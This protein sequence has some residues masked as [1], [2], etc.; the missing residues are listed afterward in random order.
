M[1]QQ[2]YLFL[3]ILGILGTTG[4][5]RHQTV[6]WAFLVTPVRER[7]LAA[8]AL[9]YGLVGL[10]VALAAA[11]ATCVTA[12]VV[13]AAQGRQVF[14]PEVLPIL[15]GSVV[16]SALYTILGLGIGA[17]VRNQIAAVSVALGWFYY[18]EFLLV[19]FLPAIG[20]WA[21][22]GAAKALIG[23]QPGNGTLLPAWAGAAVFAGYI[24]VLG[25]LASRTTLRRDV[26]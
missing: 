18:A 2:S 17:L 6:T 25:L 7:V 1:A 3:L 8:K 21:P 14:A 4:E 26:T 11:V 20:Q 22:S 13:L 23:F 10:I 19:F 24:L 15:L 5:Y 16:S 9:A 12:V